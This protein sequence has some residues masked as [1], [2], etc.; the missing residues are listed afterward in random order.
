MKTSPLSPATRERL[1]A[2]FAPSARAKAEELLVGQ[3]GNNLPF[4]ENRDMFGL[5]RLRFA[6][7]KVSEG[8]LDLLQRAVE[9]AQRDWR[10]LL[11]AAGFGYDIAAHQ[12]WR[13]ALPQ[14]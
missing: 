9:L 8:K 12:L 6:A 10:D 3:C 1:D 7:L 4:C 13:P 14:S 11:M 2:L 5:E